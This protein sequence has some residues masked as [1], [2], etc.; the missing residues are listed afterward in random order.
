MSAE[1]LIDQCIAYTIVDKLFSLSKILM[2]WLKSRADAVLEDWRIVWRRQEQEINV[3]IIHVSFRIH[4]S[5]WEKHSFLQ[6]DSPVISVFQ[7]NLAGWLKWLWTI[8]LI[9]CRYFYLEWDVQTTDNEHRNCIDIFRSSWCIAINT[10]SHEMNEWLLIL[11]YK[12]THT[13][14]YTC[15]WTENVF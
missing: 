7:C 3:Y 10:H 2:N 14:T 8:I 5:L 13:N 6:V 1:R 12:H 15:K 9:A 11:L 4:Y